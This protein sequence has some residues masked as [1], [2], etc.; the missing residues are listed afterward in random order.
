MKYHPIDDDV[1]CLFCGRPSLTYQ[2]P[3]LHGDIYQCGACQRTV[4]HRRQKGKPDCGLVAIL[5][6][7]NLGPWKPCGAGRAGS[8]F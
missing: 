2:R 7:A 5:N 3:G 6:F 1:R 8:R 4:V